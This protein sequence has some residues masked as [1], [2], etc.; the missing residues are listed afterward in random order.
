MSWCQSEQ[1][2]GWD[3]STDILILYASCKKAG[4]PVGIG[5]KGGRAFFP[6]TGTDCIS[7]ILFLEEFNVQLGVRVI[8]WV[9]WNGS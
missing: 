7:P 5:D 4:F 6:S 1:S 8:V 3:T 9:E 2:R